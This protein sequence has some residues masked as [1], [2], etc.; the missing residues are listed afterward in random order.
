MIVHASFAKMPRMQE[1]NMGYTEYLHAA[2]DLPHHQIQNKQIY[3]ITKTNHHTKRLSDVNIAIGLDILIQ[4]V[5]TK[6]IKDH[7]QCQNGSQKQHA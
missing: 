5:Q 7:H 1:D 4:N 2:H 3:Q 6:T